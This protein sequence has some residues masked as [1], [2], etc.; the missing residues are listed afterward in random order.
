MRKTIVVNVGNTC[1][2]V[3]SPFN[4]ID[5]RRMQLLLKKQQCDKSHR[6]DENHYYM[7]MKG[8]MFTGDINN[9]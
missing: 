3:D 7:I 4:F 6:D 5:R 1:P 2:S 8:S 9:G